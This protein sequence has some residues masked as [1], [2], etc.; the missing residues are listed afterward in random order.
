MSG[1]RLDTPTSQQKGPGREGGRRRR[2]ESVDWQTDPQGVWQTLRAFLMR[3]V[4]TPSTHP[5][6]EVGRP[7]RVERLSNA[8]GYTR[9]MLT[10]DPRLSKELSADMV[11]F[12]AAVLPV[13]GLPATATAEESYM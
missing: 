12:S 6:D 4:H 7:I 9:C 10:F 11:V 5:P 8:P 2:G 13:A 1:H 3:E